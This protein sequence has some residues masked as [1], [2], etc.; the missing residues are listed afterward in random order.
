MVICIN[1][2]EMFYM[3]WDIWKPIKDLFSIKQIWVSSF[4]DILQLLNGSNNEHLAKSFKKKIHT[5]MFI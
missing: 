2:W 3:L 5:N 4:L 1:A